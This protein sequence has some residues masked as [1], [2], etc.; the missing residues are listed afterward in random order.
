VRG[1]GDRRGRAGAGR[2]WGGGRGE[3]GDA[4]GKSDPAGVPV[5]AKL[6]AK[7]STYPLNLGGMSAAEFRET[8][9][10]AEKNGKY[11]QPP[12]VDLVLELKNTSDKEVQVWIGGDRCG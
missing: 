7:K 3:K 2:R 10:A 9:K 1:P 4:K 8:I 12:A 6:I 11:P 5:Q